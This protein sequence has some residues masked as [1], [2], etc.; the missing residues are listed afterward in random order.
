M[1]CEIITIGNE[2]VSG[3]A[4]DLNSWYAAGRLIASGLGV[5]R[6]TSVGDDPEMVS[7]ALKRAVRDSGFV[8]ITGGLGSTDDDMTSE[9]AAKALERPLERNNYLFEK[10]K[11]H[12]ERRGSQ[13]NSS[14]SKMAFMPEGS[15]IL[16]PKGD[17]CGY[18]LEKGAVRLYFLPGVP[19]QMRYLLDKFVLPEIVGCCD[20]LPV[21]RQRILKLYGLEEPGISE[22]LKELKGKTGILLGFYPDFPEN[23]ITLSLRGENESSVTGELDRAEREIRRLI[24]EYIFSSGPESMAEVVGKMLLKGSYTI[25]VAESCT[26]GLLGHRLTEVPGSSG[27]F[28]GGIVA[29]SNRAKIDLLKVNPETLDRYGA[30]SG[31]TA[32]EMA[33]GVR[34]YFRT[35]LG[36]SVTGIAGP[37]GGTMSKPVG[38]VYLGIDGEKDTFTGM[39]RFRGSRE[40]VKLNASAMALDWIRRYID[41]YPFLPGI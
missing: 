32:E 16:N 24:G 14:L 39:Y 4:L 15:R 27:Y 8:I 29:Y 34:K 10:I 22:A 25:S 18:S 35:D 6:I 40:K 1:D 33:K 28:M 38:T 12:F 36:I 11:G 7:N 2:L 37:G 17:A 41:G 20:T 26:G 9:I 5:T 13:M 30:V 23:H 19:D 3:R 31:N 21:M